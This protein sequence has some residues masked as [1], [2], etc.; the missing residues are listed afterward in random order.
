MLH[1]VEMA[2]LIR[3]RAAYDAIVATAGAAAV[4]QRRAKS[5]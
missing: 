5:D 1:A 4:D 3:R 2:E